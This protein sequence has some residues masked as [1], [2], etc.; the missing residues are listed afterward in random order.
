MIIL[1]ICPCV[2]AFFLSRTCKSKTA[3]RIMRWGS[4][5]FIFVIIA[6]TYLEKTCSGSLLKGLGGCSTQFITD[7]GHLAAAPLLFSSL[8][9]FV[10]SPIL[11]LI[12]FV[13]ETRVRRGIATQHDSR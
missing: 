9:Y 10:I 4:V 5:Y 8:G 7:L 2:I 3:K 11:L 1:L 12:A 13:F 6:A